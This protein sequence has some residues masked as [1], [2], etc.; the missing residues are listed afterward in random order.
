MLKVMLN[1]KKTQKSKSNNTKEL[2]D[3]KISTLRGI[4]P[5]TEKLSNKKT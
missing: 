2:C 3:I 4:K 5:N 1:R